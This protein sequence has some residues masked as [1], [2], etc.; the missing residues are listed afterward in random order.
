MV[1]KIGYFKYIYFSCN[2]IMKLFN[3]HV[4]L[5]MSNFGILIK[6]EMTDETE[7]T[8]KYSVNIIFEYYVMYIIFIPH[9]P[10]WSYM[11]I[12]YSVLVC[13]FRHLVLCHKEICPYHFFRCSS[14]MYAAG[15]MPKLTHIITHYVPDY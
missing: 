9:I 8:C 2:K 11:L 7:P 3:N 10:R 14:M 6:Q 1:F 15:C 12:G 13:N 4:F 5:D